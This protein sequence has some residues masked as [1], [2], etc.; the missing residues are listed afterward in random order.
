MLRWITEG[1]ALIAVTALAVS[2]A[3]T[4]DAQQRGAPTLR[5]IERVAPARPQR[6]RV[7]R[8]TRLTAD[9]AEPRTVQSGLL[10]RDD[11]GRMFRTGQVI[12][13]ARDEATLEAARALG[14]IEIERTALS[15]SGLTLVTLR[16]PDDVDAIAGVALLRQ[17]RPGEAIDLNVIYHLQ[18]DDTLDALPEENTPPPQQNSATAAAS[19]S[20][21]VEHVLGPKPDSDPGPR[22]GPIAALI[23]GP[24]G[25]GD[26][27]ASVR[28]I[29]RNFGDAPSTDT[30]HAARVA[31]Q[32]ANA[33]PAPMTLLAANVVAVNI[34]GA[35]A[36]ALAR[37]LDWAAAEGATVINVSL[38]GP[39]N[40]A[41][42]AVAAR[43]A[44]QGRIIVAAAGN[45]GPRAPPAY[46]AAYPD[47][48][49]VT[50][51]NR[52]DRIWRRANRGEYVD[53]AALGVRIDINGSRVSGTSY[54]A[55]VVAGVLLRYMDHVPS[56][57]GRLDAYAQLRAMATDLGAP[58]DD[59][60]FGAGLISPDATALL[61]AR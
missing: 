38:A 18:D 55:P 17:A 58:G 8:L 20:P 37:A 25:V 42:E 24:L 13:A 15:A 28:V 6:R 34:D 53:F 29:R 44:L 33:A 11:S 14:F 50:A 27:P 43:L 26:A 52:R 12:V 46:P 57:Q 54:A 1:L 39:H 16:T 31:H 47:V 59:P 40:V 30:R 2:A 7:E 56:T 49:A 60:I 32:F 41:V 51:V 9:E 5:R 3:P 4:A 45:N 35:S 36:D 61:A 10:Q 19:P 23:D 21:P 22:P 48:I